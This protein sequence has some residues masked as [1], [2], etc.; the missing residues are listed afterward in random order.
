M[1]SQRLEQH[2][3][4]PGKSVL[5]PCC[6]CHDFQFCA[7]MVPPSKQARRSLILQLSLELFLSGWFGSTNFD[8]V[9]FILS[10]YIFVTFQMNEWMNEEMNETLATRGK[11][12]KWLLLIPDERETFSFSNSLRLGKST[13][14]R[15]ASCPDIADHHIKTSIPYC[16]FVFGYSFVIFLVEVVIFCIFFFL[17]TCCYIFVVCLLRKLKIWVGRGR[18]ED[19]EQLR[20]GPIWS[21]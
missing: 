13:A 4:G 18:W 19:L 9:V 14:P 21:R 12:N 3:Q 8:T 16:V 6:L 15:Q 17:G 2:A 20:G 7:F 1:N 5:G 11:V 10:H